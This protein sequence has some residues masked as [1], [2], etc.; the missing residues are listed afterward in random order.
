MSVNFGKISLNIR[1]R[2]VVRLSVIY[3]NHLRVP[4]F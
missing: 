4:S 2:Q 1:W 3:T